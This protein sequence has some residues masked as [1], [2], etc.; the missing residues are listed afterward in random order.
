MHWSLHH[1]NY[2][3]RIE[4]GDIGYVGKWLE[5]VTATGRDINEVVDDNDGELL[6]LKSTLQRNGTTAL[7]YAA[8][9]SQLD[10]VKLL[11]ENGAGA[12]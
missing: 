10:I 3:Q 12:H 5:E 9:Y 8:F 4:E 1:N 11:L 2:P 7:N 6:N